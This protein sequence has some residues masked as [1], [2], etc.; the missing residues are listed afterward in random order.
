MLF[1]PAF[2]GRILVFAF[3]VLHLPIGS[4]PPKWRF[5]RSRRSTETQGFAHTSQTEKGTK[6]KDISVQPYTSAFQQYRT[7]S[8]SPLYRALYCSTPNNIVLPF[9]SSIY[10]SHFP[11]CFP[12]NRDSC[13]GGGDTLKTIPSNGN[14]AV[15]VYKTDAITFR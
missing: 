14:V 5:F 12:F 11:L 2:Q 7:G 6:C 1:S 9:G 4:S 10:I 15:H 13:C 3:L 8:N